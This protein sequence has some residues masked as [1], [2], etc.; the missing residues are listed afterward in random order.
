LA[1]F[2][3]AGYFPIAIFGFFPKDPFLGQL[4]DFKVEVFL[5]RLST[6]YFLIK[7]EKN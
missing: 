1:L 6:P 2:D 3:G 4:C 5:R 7:E